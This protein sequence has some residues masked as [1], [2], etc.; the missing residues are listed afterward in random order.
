MI[1]GLLLTYFLISLRSH[2]QQAPTIA[3][4]TTLEEDWDGTKLLFQSREAFTSFI[5]NR[6]NNRIKIR[7]EE[8]GWNIASPIKGAVRK[9]FIIDFSKRLHEIILERISL[10]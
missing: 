2:S 4:T 9:Q 10:G 1:A 8:D 6:K 3:T 7:K 5:L